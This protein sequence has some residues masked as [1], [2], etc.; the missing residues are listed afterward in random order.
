MIECS[1]RMSNKKPSFGSI[2]K[3]IRKI[4]SEEVM[5]VQQVMKFPEEMIVTSEISLIVYVGNGTFSNVKQSC[6][7]RARQ[8]PVMSVRGGSDTLDEL[9]LVKFD[10]FE[11]RK[12]RICFLFTIKN[13][14]SSVAYFVMKEIMWFDTLF[15]TKKK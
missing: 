4:G 15:I 12:T 14:I 6:L 11:V 1:S 9:R 2:P 3:I 5:S 8:S 13:N 7:K 10:Q